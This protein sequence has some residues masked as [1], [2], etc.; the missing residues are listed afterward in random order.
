[1]QSKA[2]QASERR[3]LRRPA[4]QWH[5][6]LP[7]GSRAERT[8]K[9]LGGQVRPAAH[10]VL[11]AVTKIKRD[12]GALASSAPPVGTWKERTRPRA[13]EVD[14]G[15]ADRRSNPGRNLSARRAWVGSL[16]AWPSRVVRVDGSDERPSHAA[17]RPRMACMGARATSCACRARTK[18]TS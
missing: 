2:P 11:V 4:V 12:P 17:T 6:R 14:G 10:L 8:W 16:L 9:R 3:N 1:M 18:R 15:M 13:D 5:A 7:A